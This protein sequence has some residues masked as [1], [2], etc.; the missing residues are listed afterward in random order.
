MQK[1]QK[2]EKLL[3]TVFPEKDPIEKQN[4]KKLYFSEK[5]KNRKI[6]V[7]ITHYTLLHINCFNNCSHGKKPVVKANRRL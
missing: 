2:C 6:N 5:K 7:L 4:V 3:T 1:R